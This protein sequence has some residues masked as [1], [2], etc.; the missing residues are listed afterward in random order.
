MSDVR[1]TTGYPSTAPHLSRRVRTG[2]VLCITLGILT[3]P[4]SFIPAAG[5]GNGGPPVTVLVLDV[6]L[7]LI[8]VGGATLFWR[9]GNR[10]ANRI[11]AGALILNAITAL[12]AFFV[13]VDAWVKVLVAIVTLLTVAA[14]VL[15][16]SRPQTS[17]LTD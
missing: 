10:R 16:L 2:L 8:E 5:T 13:D 3:I 14:V 7:G 17:P 1:P 12:P 6:L 15:Q 4:G 9:T 11:A